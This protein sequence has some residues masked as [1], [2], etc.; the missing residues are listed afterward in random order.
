V[1]RFFR[2]DTL[3]AGRQRESAGEPDLLLP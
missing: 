1:L 2:W 3:G